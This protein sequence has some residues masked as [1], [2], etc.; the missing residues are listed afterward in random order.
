M[1]RKIATLI[2][3]KVKFTRPFFRIIKYFVT[4]RPDPMWHFTTLPWVDDEDSLNY[5]KCVDDVKEFEFNE[6][7]TATTKENIDGYKSR[8]WYVS[9][10]VRHALNFALPDSDFVECGVSL[11]WTAL[12]TLNEVSNH[13]VHLYDAWDAMKKENLFESEYDEFYKTIDTVVMV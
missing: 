4:K 5:L 6:F 13:K 7:V 3:Q 10:A 8:H 2:F 11:G 9:F 12:F 1:F